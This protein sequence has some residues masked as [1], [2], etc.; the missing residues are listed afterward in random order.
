MP[1]G[2]ED[3][4]LWG[5]ELWNPSNA[6]IASL[7]RS[8]RGWPR[9]EYVAPALI[10]EWRAVLRAEAVRVQ[11]ARRTGRNPYPPRPRQGDGPVSA[12]DVILDFLASPE[13]VLAIDILLAMPSM[14]AALAASAVGMAVQ[15][16]RPA[17]RHEVAP[18][19]A[20]LIGK[21]GGTPWGPHW[22]SRGTY[23]VGPDGRG[24]RLTAP[25]DAGCPAAYRAAINAVSPARARVWRDRLATA[26]PANMEAVWQEMAAAG[27]AA[28][29]AADPL[30]IWMPEGG[31]PRGILPDPPVPPVDESA[32]AAG[33]AARGERPAFVAGRG[34]AA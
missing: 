13:G 5:P 22:G 21:I 19:Y 11:G 9:D 29:T 33:G 20:Y 34:G 24:R 7:I 32:P 2:E 26:A 4:E 14:L 23:V 18:V 3:P 27:A 15:S 10:R 1:T 12:R 30:A 16:L 6:W 28:V 25:S 8:V 17:V 31:P